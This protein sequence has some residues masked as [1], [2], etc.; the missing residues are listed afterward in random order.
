[1]ASYYEHLNW[2]NQPNILHSHHI[3]RYKPEKGSSLKAEAL[4]KQSLVWTLH[5]RM[6]TGHFLTLAKRPKKVYFLV[7][8][9]IIHV[10]YFGK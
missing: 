3:L 6:Y 8:I 1:M 9:S 4:S 10:Q 7:Y 5:F 2:L